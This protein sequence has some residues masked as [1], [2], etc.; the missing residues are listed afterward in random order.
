MLVG[1]ISSPVH[2]NF[3]LARNRVNT[4]VL[5]LCNGDLDSFFF[6]HGGLLSFLT[7]ASVRTNSREW[8]TR[9][10]LAEYNTIL[11]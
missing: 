5:R 8:S 3:D 6:N 1:R 7:G 10:N 11:L 4:I 9:L 2:T